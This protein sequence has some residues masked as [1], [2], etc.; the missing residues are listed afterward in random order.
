MDGGFTI[1]EQPRRPPL[2]SADAWLSR[3]V[4]SRTAYPQRLTALDQSPELLSGYAPR[5]RRLQQW[6]QAW[7]DDALADLAECADEAREEGYPEPAAKALA[8]AEAILKRI[9]RLPAR[10]PRPNVYPTA[11]QE[12]DLFFRRGDV[13]AA[14]LVLVE[15]DGSVACFSNVCGLRR[16]RHE[17]INDLMIETIELELRRLSR[18]AC[19]G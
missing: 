13:G 9:A 6:E 4:S 7:L 2:S 16:A 15:P 11:D 3:H 12:I 10:L 19:A 8:A 17:E 18:L 5:R 1:P 14:V